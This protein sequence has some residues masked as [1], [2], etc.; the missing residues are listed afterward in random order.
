[1]KGYLQRLTVGVMQ[2]VASIHPRVGS[3]F[4]PAQYGNTRPMHP[5]ADG[6]LSRTRYERSELFPEEEL[7]F[8]RQKFSDAKPAYIPLMETVKAISAA[9][10]SSHLPTRTMQNPVRQVTSSVRPIADNAE[11]E[12]P[13]EKRA[14]DKEH[15][16]LYRPMIGSAGR[17]GGN[18][19]LQHL[20]NHSAAATKETRWADSSARARPSAQ[21]DEIQIHIGRIEVTA[22]QQT[23]PQPTTRP[24]RKALS[25][26]EY[27]KRADGR[28]R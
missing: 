8:V 13:S 15:K 4:S 26:D 23:S 11:P 7:S 9:D 25:L 27:L 22:V 19:A 5:S 3:V 16:R 28:V 6:D 20:A 10:P 2:P 18:E 21:P 1:M 14:Q 17:S 12:T 24:A